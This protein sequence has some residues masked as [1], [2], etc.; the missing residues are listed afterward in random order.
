M[1]VLSGEDALRSAV[2]DFLAQY[3]GGRNHQGIGNPF[4]FPDR[5]LAVRHGP[6]DAEAISVDC[7]IT[8]T[9][10][11]DMSR[12]AVIGYYGVVVRR[13]RCHCNLSRSS[14][15]IFENQDRIHAFAISEFGPAPY[16]F[17]QSVT[18]L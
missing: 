18:F 1:D 14:Q 9:E 3:H 17:V 11:P 10:R 5:S 4:I 2:R 8:M 15:Q 13:H 6:F 7:S 12:A 16:D